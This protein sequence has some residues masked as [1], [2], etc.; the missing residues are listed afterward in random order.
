[1][2]YGDARFTLFS[3]ETSVNEGEQGSF[4]T[5][6]CACVRES[7]QNARLGCPSGVPDDVRDTDEVG[8]RAQRAQCPLVLG[9]RFL[10]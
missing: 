4:S 6:T 7:I 3:V 2:N 9:V 8:A 5:S 1:M 10:L